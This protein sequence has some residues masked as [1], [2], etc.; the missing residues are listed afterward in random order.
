[1]VN[2]AYGVCVGSWDRFHRFVEPRVRGRQLLVAHGQP[3]ITVAYNRILAAFSAQDPLPDALVL[4]HEDLEIIDPDFEV[5]VA[6]ELECPDVAL[7]GVAGGRGVT[8]L[9]WWEAP[10]RFGHQLT[11]SGPLELGPRR[12][13]VDSLEGSL[14][15]FSRWAIDHLR[16]DERLTGFHCCDEICIRA[17][18]AGRAVKVADIDTHHHTVVG[19]FKSEAARRE[20]FAND[21]LYRERE[22]L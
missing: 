12:G 22:Q 1:V 20:W 16:Y 9:A 6:W 5:K 17:V 21:A 11:D 7:V 8:S 13:D 4:L 18:R 10:E 15:V 14:L 2:I 3:S 19:A